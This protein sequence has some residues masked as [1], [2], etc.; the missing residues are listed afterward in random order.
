MYGLLYLIDKKFPNLRGG[1]IHVP[2]LPEQ[3]LDKGN[4]PSMS[5]ENITKALRLAIEGA[6]K[7]KEDIKEYRKENSLIK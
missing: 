3:V 6:L 2:F 7:Y 5:T 1:F 4:V